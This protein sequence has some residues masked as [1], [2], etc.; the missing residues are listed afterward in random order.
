MRHRNPQMDKNKEVGGRKFKFGQLIFRKIMKI[1]ATR[2][3]IL[4]L[5]CTKFDLTSRS[6]PKPPS[7]ILGVLLLR[8][9][10]GERARGGRPWEGGEEGGEE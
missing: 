6:T 4:R 2:C 3:H 10:G 7:W 8:E 9:E 1:V 5:K